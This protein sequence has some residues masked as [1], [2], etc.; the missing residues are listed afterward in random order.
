[1]K[2]RIMFVALLAGTSFCAETTHLSLDCRDGALIA[3]DSHPLVYDASW[4][5]GGVTAKI[6]ANGRQIVAGT[7]DT[8]TW[9][10]RVTHYRR[11]AAPY[12][13]PRLR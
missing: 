10:P 12:G 11:Q 13:V 6:T 2:K 5:E 7:A 3:D 1:M 4:Y 8:Y 9:T